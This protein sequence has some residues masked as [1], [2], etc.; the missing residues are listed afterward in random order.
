[1]KKQVRFKEK[2]CF[3]AINLI[4][5]SK[6]EIKIARKRNKMIVN[7]FY[8]FTKWSTTSKS[9]PVPFTCLENKNK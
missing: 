6:E 4:T 1:M 8:T 5:Q 2:S 9:R 7:N 3:D